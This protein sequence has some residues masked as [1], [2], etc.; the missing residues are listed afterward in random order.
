MRQRP[1]VVVSIQSS[2][3][4]SSR[5]RAAAANARRRA[6]LDPALTAA[7]SG[8]TN[9]AVPLRATRSS[10]RA[11]RSQGSCGVMGAQSAS[12]SKKARCCGPRNASVLTPIRR[13]RLKSRPLVS[14]PVRCSSNRPA[15][16]CPKVLQPMIA[17]APGRFANRAVEG[18]HNFGGGAGAVGEMPA[19]FGEVGAHREAP[20]AQ[21]IETGV[22][23][24]DQL[25]TPGG[26]AADILADGF[27]RLGKARIERRVAG[28]GARPEAGGR[29]NFG[30][31]VQ[32]AQPDAGTD[33]LPFHGRGEPR[34]IGEAGVAALPGA[35]GV[36]Q[37]PAV[38]DH[39]EG[40]VW[41]GWSEFRHQAGIAL[42]GRGRAVA[43]V[44]VIPVVAA[45]NGRGGEARLSAELA[46][47]APRGLESALVRSAAAD[48]HDGGFQ[49]AGPRRTAEPPLRRSSQREMPAGSACQKAKH[50]APVATP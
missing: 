40:P 48:S 12:R 29:R 44:G 36:G 49:R 28:A 10:Q 27:E 50:E 34:H 17:R 31:G 4:A 24:L 39:H 7:G 22:V 42:D 30:G 9:N 47:E 43:A 3:S 21:Q 38:I 41:P 35:G 11:A 23:V 26:H 45:V 2:G 5:G 46:A 1:G 8:E 32:R 33:A 14:S 16:R 37:R 13:V 20:A 15:D 25:E 18:Q 6:C 19:G